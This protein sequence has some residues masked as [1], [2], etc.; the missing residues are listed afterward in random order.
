MRDRE[1]LERLGRELYA[2][3][4]EHVWDELFRAL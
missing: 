2:H 1:D 3:M 4:P